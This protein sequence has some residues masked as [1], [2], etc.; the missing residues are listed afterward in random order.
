MKYEETD[1][2]ACRSYLQEFKRDISVL[3]SAKRLPP[4]PIVVCRPVHP[5]ATVLAKVV[6]IGLCLLVVWA[7]VY[8]EVKQQ[9]L[10]EDIE[11]Q[12][13]STK[14][15]TFQAHMTIASLAF[16]SWVLWDDSALKKFGYTILLARCRLEDAITDACV[17]M[18]DAKRR[19]RGQGEGDGSM[20]LHV[21]LR[22]PHCSSWFRR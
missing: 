1:S 14:H 18:G 2:S 8:L 16:L 19:L 6:E 10:I 22:C 4:P 3:E 17:A 7:S 9:P 13:S 5:T 20:D 12:T 11:L 21:S 15:G